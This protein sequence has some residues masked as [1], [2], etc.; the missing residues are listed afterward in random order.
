[1]T[2]SLYNDLETVSKRLVA[3]NTKFNVYF[4]HIVDRVSGDEVSDFLVVEPKV[5]GENRVTGVAI[6]PVFNNKV[7]LIRIYRPP[8][9]AWCYEIPHGFTE[10]GETDEIAA[11]R[12]MLEET[13]HI[14]DRLTDLGYI[15]SDAG[16]VA[17]R[18]HLYLAESLNLSCL[19]ISELGLRQFC[20][21]PVAEFE[22]ML[23]DS[24]VQDSFTLSAWCRYLINKR[25]RSNGGENE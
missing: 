2:L 20:W 13:G 21:L 15:M 18:I 8:L 23:A 10:I 24:T 3:E 5:Q 6:L 25:L 7:G 17:G 22:T 12:E 11:H 19:Q 16:V 14:S 1:V 4:E 9:R